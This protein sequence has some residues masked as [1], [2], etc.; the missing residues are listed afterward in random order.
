[1]KNIL[2]KI[3]TNEIVLAV[4]IA[5]LIKGFIVDSRYVPSSSMYPTLQVSDRLLVNKFLYHFTKP[6]RGDII[7]F[8]PPPI[9]HS[10]YDFV[11]RIIALPGETVEIKNGLV[12]INGKPLQEDYINEPPDYTFGPAQVPDDSLLV[13]GDNR[14]HSYDGHLWGEWLDIDAIKG[15][16]FFRYWPIDRMGPVD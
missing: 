3:L 1:M 6:Q 13:L 14:N 15:K 12:Y 16:V 5:L 11:K 7:V 9:V 8:Q 10:K 4:I 2:R